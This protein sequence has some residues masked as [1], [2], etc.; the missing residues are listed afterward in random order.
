M[1]F[2]TRKLISCTLAAASAI[3][4]SILLTCVPFGPPNDDDGFNA[5]DYTFTDVEYSPDGSSVTI[6]LDG[7]APVRHSRA[8]STRLAILGHDLFEVTFYHPGSNTIRRTVWEVGH[9]AGVS[10]VTRNVTYNVATVG[11]ITDTD[12]G[13]A[14]LFVGKKSDKTLLAVGMLTG[15]DDGGASS[16][17]ITANTKSVTFSVVGLKAGV[18]SA[19]ENSSF[20]TA[21]RQNN[22][23]GGSLTTVN[24]NNT[25]VF[26]V[27]I[28]RQ[29]FPLFR[30][31]KEKVTG[32]TVYAEYSFGIEVGSFSTYWAGILQQGPATLAMSPPE[33]EMTP[34]NLHLNPRYPIGD[35]TWEGS[36]ITGLMKDNTT[37]VVFR[38]NGNVGTAFQNPVRFTFS[39]LP[40]SPPNPNT[41]G[42]I[43]SFSFQVPV[44]P[45]T[46]VDYRGT[47]ANI[48]S[49]YLRPGFD[50]YLYDLDDGK[51]GTGGAILI[52]TGDVEGSLSYNIKVTRNPAK[53]VYPNTVGG[54]GDDWFALL[55]IQVN[56]RAGNDNVNY[57]V[58]NLLSIPPED[59]V[60]KDVRFYF[61]APSNA[62]P[63]GNTRRIYYVGDSSFNPVTGSSDIQQMAVTYP[64]FVEDGVVRIY[65]EYF[66]PNTQ[67][68]GAQ[69]YF[70]FFEVYLN[71]S[72]GAPDSN[73]IPAGN[74]LVIASQL[75]LTNLGNT[76]NSI[77]LTN[78][79]FVIVFYDSF[80]IPPIT[81]NG[82]FKI[83]FIAG[84]PGLTIGRANVGG[85]FNLTAG[86]SGSDIY[87]GVWPFNDTLAVG[88][89]AVTTYPFTI[90]AV[91][92]VANPTLH[93]TGNFINRGGYTA[94]VEVGPGFTIVN[95]PNVNRFDPP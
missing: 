10:G 73:S 48:F 82:T 41:N 68:P 35:G 7:S 26:P 51:G 40:P 30:L 92:T 2:K 57:I 25:E 13:A 24:I 49:W 58:D 6:Y 72:S 29:L 50:S 85:V 1:L 71:T 67:A 52:G 74:R 23:A 54:G 90:H 19:R 27:M 64:Q 16:S 9:A 84:K 22:G 33:M 62:V 83:I 8:L 81:P 43:F 32:Q 59:N 63:T 28:G 60:N 80:D 42:Q 39:T 5:G 94:N 44:Y 66:D 91:G 77:S 86:S 3:L 93:A 70:D 14:I 21:A 88:G 87:L 46:N 61:G 4:A 95:D 31:N 56:L 34:S 38:D 12:H 45:L 79:N 18:N 55:G 76:L 47:T 75:D 89:Q 15:T 11:G 78:R 69:P 36:T 65:V 17:L 20:H 37:G 53:R